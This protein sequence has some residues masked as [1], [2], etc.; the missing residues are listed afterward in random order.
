MERARKLEVPEP[1]RNE[2]DGLWERGRMYRGWLLTDEG[3]SNLRT[4]VRREQRDRYENAL[5]WSGVFIGVVG[6]ISG[7]IAVISAAF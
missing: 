2:L 6:A 4:A 5:R 7:L 3:F 1:E